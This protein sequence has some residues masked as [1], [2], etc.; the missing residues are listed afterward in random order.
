MRG[1]FAGEVRG[2]LA[3]TYILLEFSCKRSTIKRVVCLM[4]CKS[5]QDHMEALEQGDNT[6]HRLLD[7]LAEE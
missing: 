4:I 2:V 5:G 6:I 1:V 3:S 7:Q